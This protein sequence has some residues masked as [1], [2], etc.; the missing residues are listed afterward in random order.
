MMEYRYYRELK[1]NYLIVKKEMSTTTEDRY[2]CRIAE[3]GRIKGLIPCS[4][5]SINGENYYYYEIGSMQTLRDRF[6]SS[7]MNYTQLTTLLND[8]KNLLVELS[9]FLLGQEGLIFNTASIYTDLTTGSFRFMYCPFYDEEKNFSSFAMDLLSLVDEKDEKATELVY[10][11]CEESTSR[12]DFVYELIQECL[13]SGRDEEVPESIPQHQ[14]IDEDF[15]LDDGQEPEPVYEKGRRMKRAGKRLSGKMQLLFSLMFAL[16]LAGMV[17]IRVNYILS[18]GEN[19]LSILVMIV[20]AITGVA[21]LVGG[22]KEL[23]DARKESR[24]DSLVKKE[25]EPGGE[26]KDEDIYA[27]EPARAA[28]KTEDF[29]L[30]V[31]SFKKT[32]KVT[33]SFPSNGPSFGE[34]VVLDEVRQEGMTLFS[35]N[36]DKTERIS[37][38]NLPVTIG[39]MAGCVDR[40]IDDM[41]VS[42]IH[43]RFEQEGEDRFFVRDLGSTNGTFKN[44][45]R[46][47]PQEKVLIDEGDEIRIGRVCFDCR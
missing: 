39:K 28:V 7:G 6:S 42:R 29:P 34:T 47:S 46:L 21:A 12:E 14:I 44:G 3:S 45:V 25:T 27:N 22:F 35:R 9:D 26:E 20:S 16:L 17:Y 37:L 41:S 40:V 8:I 33:G 31:S 11:L 30:G 5:R 36:L 2:R 15:G 13:E 18:S 32:L 19:M 23:K 1:H 38:E 4:E 10:R 24:E 43:C